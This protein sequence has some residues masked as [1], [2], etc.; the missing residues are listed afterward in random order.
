MP[1]KNAAEWIF[2][3][4]ISIQNQ[5][6]ENWEVIGVNDSSTDE[7]EEIF[8]EFQKND[9]RFK[10]FQNPGKGIIPALDFA[11]HQSEGKYISRIDADD[12]MPEK[13]LEQMRNLIL[14]SPENTVVTGLVQY[15]ADQPISEG[16][17]SYESWINEINLKGLQSENIYRECV[18]ASPNWLTSREVM[19]SVGG[20]SKLSYPEDYDLVLKWYEK[21]VNFRVVPEVTLLWRE[22]SKRTSRNSENYAQEAFFELKIKAFLRLD[23]R[24]NLL[25]VWGKNPKSKL[26]SMILEAR[27]IPFEHHDL[28]DYRNVEKIQKPK[29]LLAV[30]PSENERTRIQN[31]LISINLMEGKDWWW[32]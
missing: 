21:A 27:D 31:Y 26:I 2:D 15:F 25:I 20:F 9:P 30:Y 29:I 13:R 32:V 18:I 16:Y 28:Q 12:L 19:D 22:H 5:S 1:Y 3:C 8:R 11:F 23:F 7:S 4:L 14:D 24:Q 10:T 6:F 17:R